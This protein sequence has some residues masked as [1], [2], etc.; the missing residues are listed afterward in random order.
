M[1]R[2]SLDQERADGAYLLR[3]RK[4]WHDEQREAA[5]AGPHG[6]LVA[7]LLDVLRELTLGGGAELVTFI[8]SQNWNCVNFDTR[9]I[10]LF[11]PERINGFPIIK[12]MMI[13]S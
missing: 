9:H 2:R 1:P 3:N 6:A 8:S 7:Q 13:G 4:S 12:H 5:V 11:G 10:C